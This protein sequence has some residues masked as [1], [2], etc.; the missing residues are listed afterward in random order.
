MKITQKSGPKVVHFRSVL[1]LIVTRSKGPVRVDQEITY[2]TPKNRKFRVFLTKTMGQTAGPSCFD[3]SG[4]RH[5][6][7]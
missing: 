7:G 6:C 5:G 2:K 1:D 3:T 4:I